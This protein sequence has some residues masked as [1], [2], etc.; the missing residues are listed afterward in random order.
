MD[1]TGITSLAL[2]PSIATF[3]Y[4]SARDLQLAATTK[5]LQANRTQRQLLE[6]WQRQF[7]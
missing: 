1:R 2:T 3:I 7:N 4:A 6:K 5:K